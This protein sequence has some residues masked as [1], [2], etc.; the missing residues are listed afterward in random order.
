MS[1]N[2]NS[3]KGETILKELHNFGEG[4]LE[5]WSNLDSKA[6]QAEDYDS[7]F[8]SLNGK[9]FSKAIFVRNGN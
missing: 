4:F 8:M 1:N 3:F 6:Q 9:S 7:I 5:K 2:N